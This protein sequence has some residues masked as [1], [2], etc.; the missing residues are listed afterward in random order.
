MKL[1]SKLRRRAASLKK[2][3]TALYYAYRDPRAPAYAKA[4]VFITLAYALSPVDLIPDF[5]PL[6]GYLDD[7]I[8]LPALIAL[9]I[10]WIPEPIMQEARMRAEKEPLRLRKN[11][12]TALLFI[13]IWAVILFCIGKKIIRASGG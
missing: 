4:L 6:L 8:L 2:E 10:S 11:W 7:L 3:I 5:I 12:G 13:L 9:S 1:L